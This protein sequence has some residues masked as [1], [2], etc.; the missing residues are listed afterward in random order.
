MLVGDRAS[1]SE[2]WAFWLPS[3]IL[4]R[5]EVIWTDSGLDVQSIEYSTTTHIFAWYECIF[6][7][8]NGYSWGNSRVPNKID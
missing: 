8:N 3:A 1:G 4:R 7:Q 5:D 2:L 6:Q